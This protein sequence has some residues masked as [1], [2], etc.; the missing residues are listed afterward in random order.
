MMDLDFFWIGDKYRILI[1]YD[2]VDMED[3]FGFE[4]VEVE[5]KVEHGDVRTIIR[6]PRRYR[7][8]WQPNNQ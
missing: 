5:P 7:R 8:R 4:I 2:D 6:N 1:V 3:G